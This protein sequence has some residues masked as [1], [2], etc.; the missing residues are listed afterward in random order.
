M[1]LILRV[2]ALAQAVGADI[3]KL[4]ETQVSAHFFTAQSGAVGDFKVDFPSGL[5]SLPPRH[6]SAT[7]YSTGGK[8]VL[9]VINSDVSALGF[10]GRV[11]SGN[12]PRFGY[13]MYRSNYAGVASGKSKGEPSIIVTIMVCE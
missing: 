7:A 11:F 4:R 3:K 12:P 8:S 9:A 1:S 10:S 13:G 2:K 6:V 5:F